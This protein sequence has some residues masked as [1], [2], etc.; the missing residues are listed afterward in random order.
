MKI[1]FTLL[2]CGFA[3]PLPAQ[4]PAESNIKTLFEAKDFDKIIAQYGSKNNEL[5]AKSLY[6]LAY[7][8]FIKEND[9]NCLRFVDLSLAKDS[10]DPE[11]YFLKGQTLN[12]LSRFEEAIKC[13]QSAIRL[14][15]SKGGYYS[16]MGDSYFNL[17]EDELALAAYQTATEQP[18]APD[19]AFSMIPQIYS[20]RN[21][22]SKALEAFYVAK[23]KISKETDSYITVLFNIGLMESLNGNH[24]KAEPIFLEILQLAPDDYQ[25][26]AKLIQV[27]YHRREYDKAK[28]YKDKLYEASKKGLLK[29]NLADMF[30]F[31]QFKWNDKLIQAFERYEE[32]PKKTIY[33]KHLFYVVTADNKIEYRIQTEY[34]PITDELGEAKYILC[35]SKG[36]IHYTFS[37]GFNDDFKYEDLKAAVIA[38]LDGKLKAGASSRRSK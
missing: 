16:A 34:S 28:P 26:Y 35:M 27:Y 21:E 25:T 7:S 9:N 13:F 2:I 32:G 19:R 38:I 20:N 33:Y 11:S 8:Y 29:D 31:D 12:Y 17:K 14:N 10:T 22:T 5:S 6:Y 1:L 36:D 24:D 37:V 4:D 18:N 30:C 3:I 23:S 15:P